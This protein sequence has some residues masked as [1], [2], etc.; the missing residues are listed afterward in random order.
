MT[1]ALA[2]A[3]LLALAST[4]AC[5]LLDPRPD[6]SRFFVLASLREL[7]TPVETCALPAG[8]RVGVGPVRLPEYLQHPELST[9]TSPTELAR[10]HAERWSEPLET[11]LPRVLADDLA[12]SFGAAPGTNDAHGA[13]TTPTTIGTRVVLFPWYST[14][15]PDWQIEVEIVGFEPDEK[16]EVTLI[17]RWRVRELAGAGRSLERESRIIRKSDDSDPARRAQTMSAAVGALAEE[18]ARAACELAASK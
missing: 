5:G 8:T 9:R 1:R 11:M 17:A 7:G 2:L 13:P 16:G 18:Q 3:L 10:S 12:Q 6:P 15:R 14:D 4:S